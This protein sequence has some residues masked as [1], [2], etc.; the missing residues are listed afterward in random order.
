[1]NNGSSL[2]MQNQILNSVTDSISAVA[3]LK[4]PHAL[5]FIEQ[6]AALIAERFAAGSK[7]IIAGNGGSLCDAAHFAEELTGQFRSFR[8]ALPA[9][10]LSEPGHITCTGNDMGFEWI[11]ARGVEAYGKPGDIFVGLT[12]SGNSPNI[13]KAVEF[14]KSRNL[15]TIAFLGKGGG[16]LKGVADLELIIDHYKTSDR[17]QEAHMAAIH[18]IIEMVEQ[19][20]FAENAQEPY[21]F[22]GLQSLCK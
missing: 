5:R 21:R 18:I 17:I 14:A 11:F 22:Q 12:T 10:A 3:Q 8:P 9:I 20:L 15:A 7:V 19:L 16:K 2:P 6:A 13:V 1:M 4:E